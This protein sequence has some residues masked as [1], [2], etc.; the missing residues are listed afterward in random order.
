[1]R[2]FNGPPDVAPPGSGVHPDRLAQMG[3]PSHGQQPPPPPAGNPPSHPDNR[4]PIPSTASMDRSRNDRTAPGSMM[5]G[6]QTPEGPERGRAGGSRRQL[7]GINNMLQANKPDQS[8]SH[9]R[10]NQPRTML[11]NSDVQ[12]LAGGSPVSTPGHERSDPMLRHHESASKGP[13]NGDEPSRD[14]HDRSGRRDRES[15]SDRRSSRRSSRDRERERSPTREKESKDHRD[16]RDRRSGAG[17]EGPTRDDRESSRRSG[18]NKE[19]TMPPPPPGG[20]ESRHRGGPPP[21]EGS[22]R[23]SDERREDR[24]GR[25]RRSEGEPVGSGQTSER[26]KRPRR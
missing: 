26:E 16:Y 17:T 25:K 7:A 20:R 2:N 19:P 5:P 23:G 8:R 14:E 6:A 18:R 21:K 22:S 9:S 1:M 4:Q 24:S 11:G 10:R 3:G 15:R 12:V 13:S